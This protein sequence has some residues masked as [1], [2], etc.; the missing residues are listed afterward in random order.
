M[1]GFRIHS[2]MKGSRQFIKQIARANLST[3]T[4][5]TIHLSFVDYEGNRARVPALIGQTVLDAALA[6]KIDIAGICEGGGTELDIRRTDA[7]VETVYGEGPSC[8]T[9]HVKIPSTFNHLLPEQSQGET[10]GLNYAWDE[11]YSNTS[12]LACLIKLDKRHD[13]MVIFVPDAPPT[14]LI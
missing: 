4:D 14:D 3:V 11:E 8:F 12:R 2:F 10:E 1:L 5:Q 9:C 7:W 13:G 6:H